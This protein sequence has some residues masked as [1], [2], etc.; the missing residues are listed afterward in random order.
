MG[1]PYYRDRST[2]SI[3]GINYVKSGKFTN[4]NGVRQGVVLSPIPC[5]VVP[6]L[7]VVLSHTVVEIVVHC[8]QL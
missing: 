6:Y 1:R 4:S 3:A 7:V 2:S 8:G 5:I